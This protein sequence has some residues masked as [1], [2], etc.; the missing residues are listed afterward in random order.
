MPTPIKHADA[1]IVRACEQVAHRLAGARADAG[2]TQEQV[3]QAIGL[4]RPS[5]ANFE[6]GRQDLPLS[7][8][9]AYIRVTGADPSRIIQPVDL[10]PVN[11]GG[12]A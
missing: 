2:L 1:A 5:V 4:S 8:L 7:H 3:A 9:L 11:V 6:N 12:A 10:W